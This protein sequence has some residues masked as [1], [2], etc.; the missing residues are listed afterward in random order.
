MRIGLTIDGARESS[1]VLLD[2]DDN[3]A[4]DHLELVLTE[5]AGIPVS[6]GGA[7]ALTNGM[8]IPVPPGPPRHSATTGL[9][10]HVVGGPDAGVVFN[11]VPG[12]QVVGRAGSLSWRDDTVS[13]HHLKIEVSADCVLVTELGSQNGTLLAGVPCSPGAPQLWQP[14]Q[15]L[16]IGDSVVALRSASTATTVTERAEPGWRSVARP[17]RIRPRHVDVAVGIPKAPDPPRHRRFPLVTVLIPLVAGVAMAA[18]LHHLMFLAFAVM[19]PVMLVANHVAD[20]RGAAREFRAA[21][22]RYR[23]AMS[24]SEQEL[25]EAVVSEES[26]RRVEQPDPASTRLTAV[27]G[28]RRLWERRRDDA[29]FL[30]IRIGLTDRR[31]EV[32]MTGGDSEVE[33]QLRSVPYGLD[34]SEARAVGICGPAEVRDGCLRWIIGQIATYHACDDVSLVFLAL[35]DNE[36]WRGIRWLPH[37]RSPDEQRCAAMIGNDP[38]TIAARVEDLLRLVAE[39][40]SARAERRSDELGSF[41]PVVVIMDGYR[42]LRTLADVGAVV[43]LGPAV[44]VYCLCSDDSELTLPEAAQALITLHPDTSRGSVRLVGADPVDGVLVDQVSEEWLEEVARALAPLQGVSAGESSTVPDQVRLLTLLDME[45]PTPQAVRAR[46]SA[47]PADITMALGTGAGGP[48][49]VNL[50][51]DGPHGLVAGMTGSGKS[52]L[53]QTMIVSLAATHRPDRLN[54]VLI[55][56]KGDSAF[57]DCARL[58]HTVGKVTDLD[59]HLVQRAL[60]SLA[61]E[62]LRRKQILAEAKVQDIEDYHRLSGRPVLPRLVLVIDEFAELAKDLPAFLTGLISI[63]QLGRSLGVHLLLATQRPSGVISPAIRANTNLRICLRVADAADSTDVLGSPEAARIQRGRPGRAWARLGAGD[64]VVFQAARVDGR[65]PVVAADRAPTV[66][67]A[68]WESVGYPTLE[69]REDDSRDGAT[70][71]RLLVDAITAAAHEELL[72]AQRSPW[73]EPLPTSLLWEDGSRDKSAVVSALPL[74]RSDR[75]HQ[76]RCEIATFDLARDGHL[77]LVGSPR[78]GRSQALR[79]LAAS[80]ARLTDPAQIHLYGLD[81]STGALQAVTALPH[82][83]AVVSRREPARVARLLQRLV[84]E[85][86]GRQRWMSRHGL[87]E[88]DEHRDRFPRIVLMLDG[89]EGFL[90]A[91]SDRDDLTSSVARLLREGASAGIHLAV[92]GDRLLLTHALTGSANAARFVFRLVDKADYLLAGLNPRAILEDVPP[93]RCYGPDLVETQ[94]FLLDRDPA[95]QA[96]TAV[97]REW[98]ATASERYRAGPGPRPFRLDA[99]PDELSLG[100]ARQLCASHPWPEVAIGVGG[101]TLAPVGPQLRSGPFLVAGPAGSGR[102]SVLLA[103]AQSALQAG[104]AVLVVAPRA[105]PVR[106]LEGVP[107]VAAVIADAAEGITADAISALGDRGLVVVDDAEFLQ[108]TRVG[109]A[110]AGYLRQG[111]PGVVVLLGGHGEG[112]ATGFGGWLAEVRKVRQG[113]VLSPRSALDGDLIG[114][115]LSRSVVGGP[116]RPGSGIAH[117]GDGVPLEVA[118]FV[119]DATLVPDHSVRT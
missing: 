19:S 96:Q 100:E 57:Q 36:R 116:V 89:W 62:L 118:T 110:L 119:P 14:D 83:G 77:L 75:P 49:T 101:D 71:L 42:E 111:V 22:A 26:R 5:H 1:D 48:L 74:G 3:C 12:A 109:E 64:L 28:D 47:A 94:V 25:R 46:W 79:V 15:L 16:E 78:S 24:R 115:R 76:Q 31:A 61:A 7:T 91:F 106:L 39:R 51:T 11:L 114:L 67:A 93:G 29:D 32:R 63:A 60:D 44:G 41:A 86:E 38:F 70:D 9:Q 81:C 112:L 34:L 84:E 37:L 85:L 72:P 95:G 88:I 104:R 108:N 43:R 8:R 98:G 102:S 90:T 6:L 18:F 35:A 73:L 52:A 17:P 68:P 20:R 50:R 40:E 53:L 30:R 55:D 82:C 2:C 113:M 4:L 87:A 103:A 21:T 107:G 56:Y 13:R 27:L 58:P 117:L 54:F 97:L 23:A 66:L 10:I 69:R 33:P 99:L 105:S 59:S 92:T 45:T 80:V 65:L